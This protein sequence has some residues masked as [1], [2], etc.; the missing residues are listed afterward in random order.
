[1]RAHKFLL[2]AASISMVLMAA[3]AAPEGGDNNGGATTATPTATS[4]G[5]ATPVPTPTQPPIQFRS[6]FRTPTEFWACLQTQFDGSIVN[7]RVQD[8]DLG[9]CTDVKAGVNFA[10]TLDR[11]HYTAVRFDGLTCDAT[12][13][14][15]NI[16]Y[17]VNADRCTGCV[18]EEFVTTYPAADAFATFFCGGPGPAP[19]ETLDSYFASTT[20]QLRVLADVGAYSSVV[21]K[22][23]RIYDTT[24]AL[25]TDCTAPATIASGG[26]GL[27][28][29]AC[30]PAVTS[31]TFTVGTTYDVL[32]EGTADGSEYFG[33]YSMDYMAAP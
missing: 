33:K 4:T 32:V 19:I 15:W 14:K 20:S 28:D 12:D 13:K 16:D 29:T 9:G 22:T 5:T 31:S 21:I 24:L 18:N 25:I 8:P 10:S 2:L 3:C 11:P 30:N 1:M 7:L 27:F 6:S 26:N 17:L 23:M